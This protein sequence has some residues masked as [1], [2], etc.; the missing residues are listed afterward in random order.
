MKE[1]MNHAGISQKL[2]QPCVNQYDL[3]TKDTYNTISDK[4]SHTQFFINYL[5]PLI[6]VIVSLEG[7]EFIKDSSTQLLF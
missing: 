4:K 2:N 7:V 5:D 3:V 1:L 6:H